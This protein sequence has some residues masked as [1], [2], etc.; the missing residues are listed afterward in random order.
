MTPLE[1]FLSDHGL[2]SVLLLATV[3]GDVSI[4][5]GGVL[6][7]LGLLPLP[8]VMLAGALGNLAGDCVWFG[9]GRRFR[10]P[11]RAHRFYRTVGPWIE[12]LASRLGAWQLLAARAV[13]GTRTASMIFWGQHGLSVAR[14]LLTDGLGCALASAGFA[15]LGFAVGHGTAALTGDVK[16]VEL[17]LLAG[18]L[19]GSV[20]VWAISRAI[21]RRLSR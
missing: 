21:R 18:L 19:A 4:L 9:V 16:R 8:G 6:A 14:F 2:V 20:L 7:H 5:V 15:L 11:I 17:A 12:R 13:Y 1:R 10:E 3:E